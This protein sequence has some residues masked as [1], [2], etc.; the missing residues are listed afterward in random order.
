MVYIEDILLQGSQE[1]N[2]MKNLWYLDT[3]ASSHMTSKRSF[4]ILLT[5]INRELLN[6]VM[7][8]Q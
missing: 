3:G 8:P 1:G 2:L 4:F 6:S 5:K 7:N